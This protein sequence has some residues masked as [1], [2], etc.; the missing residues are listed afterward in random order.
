MQAKRKPLSFQF[1][2]FNNQLLYSLGPLLGQNENTLIDG[3][4]QAPENWDKLLQSCEPVESFLEFKNSSD[5]ADE[6][7]LENIAEGNLIKM[8]KFFVPSCLIDR[9]GSAMGILYF[10]FFFK[11]KKK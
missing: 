5:Q 11:K 6:E 2:V 8:E 9:W 7:N 3:F 4:D 10:C 1:K